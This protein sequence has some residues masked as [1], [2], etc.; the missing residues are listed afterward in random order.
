MRKRKVM[1]NII[2]TIVFDVIMTLTNFIVPRLIITHYGSAVNGLI[3]S[4]TQFLSYLAL[5]QSGVG[6]IVLVEYYKSL[7]AKDDL[8]TTQ[9]H[10]E[11]A[12]FF[13]AIGY[14]TMVYVAVLCV[15]YPFFVKK[16]FNRKEVIAL[17]LIISISYFAQYLIG[18]TNQLIIQADQR[19]YILNITRTFAYLSS[20]AIIIILISLNQTIY[21]VKLASVIVLVFAPVFFKLYAKKH[22]NLIKNIPRDKTVLAKKWD[23]LAQHIAAFIHGNT[24]IVLL[25]VFS[26]VKEV[27]VYTVYQMVINGLKAVLSALTSGISAT[28]GNMYANGEHEK[29]KRNYIAFDHLNMIF[30]FSMFTVAEIMI[31]PFVHVYTADVHDTNYIRPAFAAIIL[32]A[33][34]VYCIRNSYTTIVYA[35]GHY[36]QTMRNSYVEAGINIV[37]SLALVKPL[38]IVGVGIGTLLAMLFRNIDYIFYLSKNIIKWDVK[39]VIYRYLVNAAGAALAIVSTRFI[40]FGSIDSF[41]KWIA[42]ALVATAITGTEIVAINF[43]FCP[44]AFKEIIDIYAL[45]LISK[46][47]K[48]RNKK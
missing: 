6:G 25:T 19:M 3:N 16:D 36:R 38:G 2:T 28:F 1:L 31:I 23:G 35:A 33:E 29:L 41:F 45:P 17:I 37:I 42:F 26:G 39:P 7:S 5:L 24:D 32:M 18:I 13:N 21:V 8:K 9:I 11:S 44:K 15:V 47:L 48:K 22:Y 46:L 27:S 4:I 40:P 43:I 14:I 10:K 30:V 20:T 12:K 34:G